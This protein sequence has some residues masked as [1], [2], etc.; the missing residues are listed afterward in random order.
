MAELRAGI[1]AI[2]A[3]LV[4]QLALR[5]RFIDRA[6]EIKLGVGLPANIPARVEQ[7]IANVRAHATAE[8][9]D[10]ELAE[11]LW[12]SLIAWS[13]AREEKAMAKDQ[14]A[15]AGVAD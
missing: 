7:V 2:D 6:A 13:I 14:M 5:A 10:P 4:R 12:R 15:G 11:T 3:E 1:D 8:G 9:L